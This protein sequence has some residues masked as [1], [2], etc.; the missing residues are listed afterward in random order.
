MS[1]IMTAKQQHF[2]M[3]TLP[4]YILR[5]HGRGFAMDTWLDKSLSPG[6][7]E[8]LDGIDRLVPLCGTIGCIGGSASILLGLKTNGAFSGF[9]HFTRTGRA[10]GLTREESRGLFAGWE[11]GYDE[12]GITHMWPKSY[13]KRYAK[14]KTTLG[15][16]KIAAE[17]CKLVGKTKGRCLH[18]KGN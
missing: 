9:P 3:E 2:L 14:A 18:V 4:A 1:E 6:E 13:R 5:E 12:D 16:A 15:K 8:Y 17:L 7:E 10:M 11:D